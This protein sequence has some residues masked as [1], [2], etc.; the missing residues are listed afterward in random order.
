[1]VEKFLHGLR[2]DVAYKFC[3]VPVAENVKFDLAR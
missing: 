2:A 1:M 3:G